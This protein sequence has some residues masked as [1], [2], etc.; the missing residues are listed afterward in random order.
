[1][2]R[3]RDGVGEAMEADDRLRLFVAKSG[4][5]IENEVLIDG[6]LAVEGDHLK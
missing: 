5:D 6:G 1:M 3:T 2:R 4:F